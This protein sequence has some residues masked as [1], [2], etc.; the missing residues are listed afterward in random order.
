M[1]TPIAAAGRHEPALQRRVVD[2]L[3]RRHHALADE[4]RQQDGRQLDGA[5]V[6]ADD[7]DR[8]AVLE[9]LARLRPRRRCPASR[10]RSRGRTTRPG[11]PRGSSGPRGGRRLARGARGRPGRWPRAGRRR[12]RGWWRRG[13]RTRG[14]GWRAPGC[15]GRAR[16]GTTA[17]RRTRRP[18]PAG[19]RA[20]GRR[21]PRPAMTSEPRTPARGAV[22]GAGADSP[23]GTG[24][25]VAV[26]PVTATR[27]PP[28]RHGSPTRPGHGPRAPATRR[29]RRATSA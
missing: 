11:R 27:P 3:H 29:D 24:C 21:A 20:A 19:P 22:T 9:R 4:V 16:S 6:H 13:P 12:C 15:G 18:R 28:R 26:V 14:R 2:R 25:S 1:L 17:R 8:P 23:A 5:V 10:A 7:D